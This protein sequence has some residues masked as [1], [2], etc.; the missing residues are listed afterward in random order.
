MQLVVEEA[1]I[2]CLMA[3]LLCLDRE[4]RIAFAL[5]EIFEASDTVGAE[6]LEITPDNF[7]QRVA[8]ARQQLRQFLTGRCGL[9]D[10]KGTCH[11]ARK[12]KD[13]IRQGIVDPAKLQFTPIHLDA[14]RTAAVVGAP[15]LQNQ[16]ERAYAQVLRAQPEDTSQDFASILRNALERPEVQKTL[17]IRS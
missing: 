6:A 5:A 2:G 9:L 14:V 1:K 12:T 11:C 13:F 7:R 15:E 3:M 16:V 17:A 4:H 10:T 8:R